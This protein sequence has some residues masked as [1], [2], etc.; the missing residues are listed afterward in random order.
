V[1]TLRLYRI[2]DIG[3]EIDLDWLAR[4]LAASYTTARTMFQRVKP[5]SISIEDPPL[6]IRMPPFTMERGEKPTTFSVVARVYDIG[7][8]SLCFVHED[9]AAGSGALEEIAFRFAGQEG[10]APCFVQYLTTLGQIMRPHIRNFAINP[11]FFEDYTVYTMD[12]REEGF[13][14]VPLL[15][16]ERGN[17]SPQ[18]RE[19]ILRN[20]L[21]YT[22]DDVVM[23]SWDSALLCTPDPPT[24]I[25]D[26]IEYANVQVLEL[27]YYDRELTRQMERMYDDIEHAEQHWRF[28]RT[29][30]YHA[31]MARQMET[32]AEVSEIIEKVNNL[33]KVTED[34]YYARVYAAA[35]KV[36][37]SGQWSESVSRKISVIHENY[38]MLSDEVRIGHSNLLEWV[39]IILIAL[40]FGLAIWQ[41]VA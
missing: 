27:R 32:Y 2:Y 33:I 13:D 7:A 22:Q 3:R 8:I 34:V 20:S 10:L 15:V 31:I 1:I 30:Q 36:L 9:A 29:F 28:V 18:M 24:D 21:S 26:L 41:S 37:R 4:E 38:L 25:T 5:T 19:E 11:E 6:T 40:E 17:F 12:R 35:L 23:L 14:P 16:G 39:I